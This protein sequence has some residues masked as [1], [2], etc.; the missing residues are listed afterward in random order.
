MGS[1]RSSLMCGPVARF[2]NAFAHW[3]GADRAFAFWKGRV[4]LYAFLKALGV[5]EGDE[6]I[7]PGYTCVM[8]VNPVK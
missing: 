7:L 3:L 4:A 5:G 8:D 6:V 1:L 2:E